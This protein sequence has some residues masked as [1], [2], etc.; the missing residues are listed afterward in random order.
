MVVCLAWRAFALIVSLTHVR[1][2]ERHEVELAYRLTVETLDATEAAGKFKD[3]DVVMS[4]ALGGKAEYRWQSLIGLSMLARKSADLFQKHYH[5]IHG[6][7]RELA[8]AKVV[9]KLAKLRGMLLAWQAALVLHGLKAPVIPTSPFEAEKKGEEAVFRGSL[10]SAEDMDDRAPLWAALLDRMAEGRRDAIGLEA[11][12]SAAGP[13]LETHPVALLRSTLEALERRVQQ[14][15]EAAAEAW[16]AGREDGSD[17]ASAARIFSALHNVACVR[18]AYVGELRILTRSKSLGA[19][20]A[21]DAREEAAASSRE[22]RKKRR[23]KT[24]ATRAQALGA[25]L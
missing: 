19:A 7:D 25:E 4:L 8:P 11:Q 20:P 10:L 22:R 6:S 24:S 3:P 18:S 14:G 1:S 23:R 5:P 12:M 21:A 17:R 16:A 2:A 13:V 9:P 15:A